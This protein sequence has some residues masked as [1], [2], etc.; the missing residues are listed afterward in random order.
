[1]W[2][3]QGY[4]EAVLSRNGSGT[5]AAVMAARQRGSGDAWCMRRGGGS[6]APAAVRPLSLVEDGETTVPMASLLATGVP[7]ATS[8]AAAAA[9]TTPKAALTISFVKRNT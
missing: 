1:M 7:V 4:Q 8:T 3:A 9:Q 2:S 6:F 5:S